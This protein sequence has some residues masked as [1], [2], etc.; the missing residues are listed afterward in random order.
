MQSYSTASLLAS[1]H[2]PTTHHHNVS[3][4]ALSND[5]SMPRG[6]SSICA[7]G[8][9]NQSRQQT[10]C[11]LP[12]VSSQLALWLV[13]SALSSK[14]CKQPMRHNVEWIHRPRSNEQQC[15]LEKKK[16]SKHQLESK[17]SNK[18]CC[19]P[20]A[21]NAS[22][23]HPDIISSPDG[24]VV[25]VKKKCLLH[26]LLVQSVQAARILCSQT[27]WLWDTVAHSY[28]IPSI[29][30]YPTSPQ[31]IKQSLSR[32]NGCT[33]ACRPS[34]CL[35]F[36]LFPPSLTALTVFK[37]H[38]AACP[39]SPRT[40]AAT[41]RRPSS[42]PLSKRSVPGQWPMVPYG[43]SGQWELPEEEVGPTVIMASGAYSVSRDLH[44]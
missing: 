30:T 8:R 39:P 13:P 23:P 40:G 2:Y 5:I 36:P 35:F 21:V 15:F 26:S 14:Q 29:H 25:V 27:S 32:R 16:L 43:G 9:I 34:L 33:H 4:I 11:L 6:Q 44:S 3:V 20:C 37:S 24:L 42:P 38:C 7:D 19:T 28:C 1:S 10:F 12:C 31:V 17:W 18:T 22:S 41:G